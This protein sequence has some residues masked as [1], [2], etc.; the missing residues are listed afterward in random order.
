MDDFDDKDEKSKLKQATGRFIRPKKSQLNNDD[1]MD[2]DQP[3]QKIILFPIEK[4]KQQEH[5]LPPKNVEPKPP[6]VFTAPLPKIPDLPHID[7]L[8]DDFFDE[9]E[10]EEFEPYENVP[11]TDF[12]QFLQGEGGIDF[13]AEQKKIAQFIKDLEARADD[14]ADN[15]FLESDLEDEE[16]IERIERLIPGTDYEEDGK[17]A[18]PSRAKIV[19]PKRKKVIPPDLSPKE[20]GASYKKT[21][22][23]LKLRRKI[24]FVLFVLSV[25]FSFNPQLFSEYIPWLEVSKHH[26]I[27]L[28]GMLLCG[29][30]LCGDLLCTGFMRGIQLKLGVDTLT[31]FSGIFC[32]LDCFVQY[33]AEEPRGE[34]PY[35]PLLLCHLTLLLYGEQEK[36][37]A[38]LRSC[39]I[40]LSA[41]HPFLI[42]LESRKWNARPAY[43]KCQAAPKGFTSQLQEDDGVQ[44]AYSFLSPV[45]LL[46]SFLTALLLTDNTDDFVW[47]FSAL[48]L[49]STPLASAFLYGRPANKISKRLGKLRSALAGWPGIAT[50]GKQCIVSDMDLFPL[51][52]SETNGSLITKGFNERKVL[53]YTAAMVIEGGL[54]C[55]NIFE[56]MLVQR[57]LLTPKVSDVAYHEGGGISARIR[58]ESVLVGSVHFME[59]M[60]IPVP[61]GTHVPN[62]IFCSINGKLGGVFTVKYELSDDIRHSLDSLLLERVRPILSTRDFALTPEMLRRSFK[63]NT[64]KMDF[65]SVTRR[66]ELSSMER[67]QEGVFTAICRLDGLE[68]V[69]ECVIA[70]RR[71]R[72]TILSSIQLS[73]LSSILGFLLVAYLLSAGSYA[74]L[75]LGNLMV[76]M[77][78]WLPPFWVLTDTAQQ[79]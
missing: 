11:K 51:G 5:E 47:A 17:R 16:E 33:H 42:I 27:V 24:S 21:L 39:K 30:L 72:K 35:V 67:P 73:L 13:P 41:D 43:T 36:L 62:T 54:G 6:I 23:S 3:T 19:P 65:P 10:L 53:A 14:Y 76:F 48:L 59:L 38:N 63:I 58:N 46:A 75:S 15:M 66:R 32:A 49:V 7:D 20:L 1:F 74:S 22:D 57:S 12:S 77:G 79:F 40:L 61:D 25:V 44:I 78:L 52:K 4:A 45:F 29:M 28:G 9:N 18:V 60:N 71:L 64:D 55:S 2:L 31:L 50:V 70:A 26:F 56:R 37:T 8:P 68:P 69:S 34:L